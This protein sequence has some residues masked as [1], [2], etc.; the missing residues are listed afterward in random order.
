MECGRG[1]GREGWS[2]GEGGR[3]REG[4]WEIEVGKVE[5]GMENKN[6]ISY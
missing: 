4:V 5:D 6:R 2:V 1:K 3:E